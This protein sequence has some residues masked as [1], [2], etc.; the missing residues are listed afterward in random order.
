GPYDTRRPLV[1]DPILSYATYF[2]GSGS[3][4]ATAIA[5][6]AQGDIYIAGIL[7]SV[8]NLPVKQLA[9]GNLFVSKLTPDG[10]AP[11][12][13]TILGNWNVARIAVDGVGSILLAG[14]TYSPDLPVVNAFGPKINQGNRESRD[15]WG[16]GFVAKLTPNGDSLVYST[17]LGG[18]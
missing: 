6:D 14:Y 5:V 18:D 16:D 12:F 2:G 17:Y 8:L 3:D 13:T 15:S 7:G 11:K 1:I 10:S 4:A 9:A